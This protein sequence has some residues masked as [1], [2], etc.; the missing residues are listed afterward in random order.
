MSG[1]RAALERLAAANTADA[2]EGNIGCIKT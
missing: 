2:G 1:M